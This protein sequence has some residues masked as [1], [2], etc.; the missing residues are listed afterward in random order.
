[1]SSYQLTDLEQVRP[2]DSSLI[3]KEKT[4]LCKKL[5]LVSEG[6]AA[7]LL[8]GNGFE[9]DG[10]PPLF[11][12]PFGIQSGHRTPQIASLIRRQPHDRNRERALNRIIIWK[13][14]TWWRGR[15]NQIAQS[16]SCDGWNYDFSFFGRSTFEDHD[17]V[18]YLVK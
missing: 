14:M 4:V 8:N 17:C 1:M 15:K 10:V 7:S 12:G 11:K 13:K 5:L 18:T 16:T 6:C 9:H 2:E 3:E